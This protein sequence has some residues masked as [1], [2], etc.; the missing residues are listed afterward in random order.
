MP[1]SI[2]RGHQSHLLQARGFG[3]TPFPA[4]DAS[5]DRIEACGTSFATVPLVRPVAGSGKRHGRLVVP[6]NKKAPRQKPGLFR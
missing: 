6:F 2:H 4:L 5:F 1:S 3:E